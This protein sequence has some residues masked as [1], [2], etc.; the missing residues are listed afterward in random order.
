MPL[1][2]ALATRH[3]LDQQRELYLDKVAEEAAQRLQNVRDEMEDT[4]HLT[5]QAE[6]ISDTKG[7]GKAKAPNANGSTTNN[8]KSKSGKGKSKASTSAAGDVSLQTPSVRS[9]R[10]KNK[11]AKMEQENVD[12]L[13]SSNA[14]NAAYVGGM[15]LDDVH[16]ADTSAIGDGMSI[17]SAPSARSKSKSTKSAK[18]INLVP[19]V[20]E[21]TPSQST[22]A[23]PAPSTNGQVASGYK[24]K[25]KP[26]QTSS[27]SVPITASL[28]QGVEKVSNSLAY[29]SLYPTPTTSAN[30]ITNSGGGDA[31]PPAAKR[32]R[33]S[34]HTG[35]PPSH[36]NGVSDT[37][38]PPENEL[39]SSAST[40]K[41]KTNGSTADKKVKGS[42]TKKKVPSSERSKH[43]AT[44][45]PVDGS[46]ETPPPP[47]WTHVPLPAPPSAT[48]SLQKLAVAVSPSA[49]AT[50]S[51]MDSPLSDDGTVN[52][53]GHAHTEPA[54]SHDFRS[55]LSPSATIPGRTIY[56]HSHQ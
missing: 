34:L 38:L 25:I 37:A 12:T 43:N 10:L 47:L 28:S 5:I 21:P 3:T 51:Q 35:G 19:N 6:S 4:S 27:Q 8:M 33:L 15:E 48:V 40:K 50:D 14:R 26:R 7:K 11:R 29:A 1:S 41:A 52:L 42:T 36:Q 16:D 9:E 30:A 46:V 55:A 18:A 20:V 49:E 56:S 13:E 44:A 32:P 45:V 53:N 31:T 39:N 2:K 22:S 23:S 17:S 24:I 54:V